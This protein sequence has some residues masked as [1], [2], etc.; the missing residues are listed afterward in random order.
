MPP[1]RT[2]RKAARLILRYLC[3]ARGRSRRVGACLFGWE[4]GGWVGGWVERWVG[5]SAHRR[6]SL[7]GS[8]MTISKARWPA[9]PSS[10]S[11]TSTSLFTKV[12]TSPKPF[13]AAFS[14]AVSTANAELSTP[15]TS[16]APPLAAFRANP[17]V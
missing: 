5:G 17:P 4:L 14:V 15:T 10:R 13:A 16:D 2:I 1:L 12:A 6:T 8:A 11:Y 9:S 3:N 7:G